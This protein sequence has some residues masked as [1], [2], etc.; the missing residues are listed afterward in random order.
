KRGVITVIVLPL[1]SDKQPKPKG[2]VTI[3]VDDREVSQP[4]EIDA[5]GRAE[6]NI[7]GINKGTHNFRAIYTPADSNVSN[8]SSSPFLKISLTE[9]TTKPAHTND[10]NIFKRW[11]FW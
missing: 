11:Y 3:Y 7:S 2:K 8:S 1:S 4:I 10:D 5:S 6:W 9:S